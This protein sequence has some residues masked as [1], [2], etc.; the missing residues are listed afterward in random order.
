MNK[1]SSEMPYFLTNESWYYHDEDEMR[2]KLT[3]KA[4][5]EAIKSYIDFYSDIEDDER[6]DAE[7]IEEGN[8]M[9]AK[10]ANKMENEGNNNIEL[11]T[12]HKTENEDLDKVEKKEEE[13]P[14][15]ARKVF[16]LK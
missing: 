10:E 7:A 8:K 11:T 16:G 3:D 14:E 2:Y 5:E 1:D 12:E 15:E 6:F 9:L 4:P 13:F